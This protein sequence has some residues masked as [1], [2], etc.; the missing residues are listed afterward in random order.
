MSVATGAITPASG[1]RQGNVST[2]ISPASN[3]T[4]PL[5][6]VVNVNGTDS[7]NSTS[8]P[9]GVPRPARFG[10]TNATNGTT[11]PPTLLDHPS[12][13]LTPMS[14]FSP[15][16][17][18]QLNVSGTTVISTTSSPQ[19]I[20]LNSSSVLTTSST[21]VST[22]TSSESS[23]TSSGVPTS[24]TVFPRA[25]V[26]VSTSPSP[27]ASSPPASVTEF[28]T[29][30]DIPGSPQST[31]TSTGTEIPELT[32]STPVSVIETTVTAPPVVTTSG[33]SNPPKQEVSGSSN[34]DSFFGNRAAVVGV[35][36]AC[37][38]AL[39]GLVLLAI[40]CFRR[41]RRRARQRGSWLPDLSYPRPIQNPF[42]K[43]TR[44]LATGERASPNVRWRWS[45]L[46]RDSASVPQSLFSVPLNRSEDNLPAAH[47]APVPQPVQRAPSNSSYRVPVPYADV[48][49]HDND[50]RVENRRSTGA[51]SEHS[52]IQSAPSSNVVPLLPIRS[53]LRPLAVHDIAKIRRENTLNTDMD[54]DSLYRDDVVASL[55]YKSETSGWLTRGLSYGVTSGQGDSVD[56]LD[57][58]AES[59][60][61]HINP[62]DS[63]GTP[64]LVMSAS[65]SSRAHYSPFDSP[66]SGTSTAH[67][68]IRDGNAH[69]RKVAPPRASPA[70]LFMQHKPGAWLRR[71]S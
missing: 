19:P 13:S 69:S 43:V 52:N 51:I 27:V 65:S 44:N 39:A 60:G 71:E 61:T 54:A 18:P 31:L 34:G 20:S 24:S 30:L 53:P 45:M 47:R 6:Y 55:P 2:L 25:S 22:R 32:F 49:E 4:L 57:E 41:R 7:I 42:A 12:A 33:L 48:G 26:P 17:N 9:S 67:T 38:F 63:D 15:R 21:P 56:R 16:A 1:Q 5:C 70:A 46:P 35:F 68:S 14:R 59:Q 3:S 8:S 28:S 37:G 58:T 62:V 29:S 10:Q 64:S 36:L 50:T 11:L 40:C 23:P 66:A